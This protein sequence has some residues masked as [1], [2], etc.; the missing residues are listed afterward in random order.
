[1][2]ARDKHSSLFA[3]IVSIWEKQFYKIDFRSQYY[4]T[5]TTLFYERSY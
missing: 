2:P 4:K 3:P 1:M 5:F